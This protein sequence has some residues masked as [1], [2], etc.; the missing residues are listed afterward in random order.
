LEQVT[1]ESPHASLMFSVTL[2][3]KSAERKGVEKN[4]RLP[5]VQKAAEQ[6][7]YANRYGAATGKRRNWKPLA[8]V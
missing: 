6:V 4:T 1:V 8:I 5:L 2:L 7:D 3:N